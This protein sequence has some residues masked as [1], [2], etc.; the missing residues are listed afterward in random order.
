MKALI[1]GAGPAGLL[2]AWGLIREDPGADIQIMDRDISF[3]PER[4]FSLQYLHHPCELDTQIRE[5]QLTYKVQGDAQALSASANNDE[6]RH[7][8]GQLYNAKL[9]REIT[10]ENST[11]FLWN[12]PVLVWSLRDAYRVLA[13]YFK[14]K[15][16]PRELTW[17]NIVA[18]CSLYDV[19]IS[20]IPLNKL[21][22]DRT[23]PVRTGL[24]AMNWTPVPLQE[25]T[26]VYDINYYTPWYRATQLDGGKATEFRNLK[27]TGD[28]MWLK[29]FMVPPLQKL[30]KVERGAA[31][32]ADL[33]S[34]LLLTGRW[35]SWDPDKLTHHAF[36]D[37]RH[38]VKV[39]Y[40]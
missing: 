6:Y 8:V 40:A 30:Y 27:Y 14:D 38:F 28:M 15:M 20:T 31:L 22:P 4:I 12:S 13:T 21:F 33:P 2:A 9:D 26:C 16:V 7:A 3:H 39:L 1:A 10:D 35:G 25:N 17:Q 37:A 18:A 32:P 36:W 19:V 29:E 5:F 34:N 23:W 24:I 11:R